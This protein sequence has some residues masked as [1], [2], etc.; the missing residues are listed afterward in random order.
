MNQ[1]TTTR[2]GTI[3]N[4]DVRVVIG[5]V[6]ETVNVGRGALDGDLETMTLL[7]A[8]DTVPA[9]QMTG[10][11]DQVGMTVI[12]VLLD[13]IH[14]L[15]A[16][17]GHP[18]LNGKSAR[19]LQQPLPKTGQNALVVLHLRNPSFVL[20]SNLDPLAETTH[21][22]QDPLLANDLVLQRITHL[23]LPIL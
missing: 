20:N 19:L 12:N 11:N 1:I 17:H 6:P 4:G 3:G 15:Q 14:V 16:V 21:R 7:D 22:N 5:L 18:V 10:E 13:D 8:G 23:H 2:T 9:L